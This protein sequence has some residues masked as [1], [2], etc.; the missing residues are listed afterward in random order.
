MLE[1]V[2]HL[3]QNRTTI[4]TEFLAGL[5]TFLAMSYILA[6]N[7]IILGKTGMDTGAIFTA[8]CVAAI[9]GTLIMAFVANWPVGMA[10]G[11]G[12]NA[13]FTYGIVL[14]MGYS[15]Q[16][17]LG[18]VFLSGMIFIVLTATGIRKWLI[19]GV[20]R[21]LRSA[22]A[23]GI[24][25]FLAFVALQNAGII[26]KNDATLISLGDMTQTAPAL[27]S[28]GFAIIVMLSVFK[29]RGA[30]LVGILVTTILSYI[31]APLQHM[32]WQNGTA[33]TPSLIESLTGIFPE[34]VI[35]MPPSL[36][37]TFL[38]LDISGI[39]NTG[40]L[41]ILLVLV[42][43][44]IFDATGTLIGVGQRTGLI[45]DRKSAGLGRALFADSGAILAGSLVGTSSTTAYMESVAGAEVGGR[46]GLT[47]LTIA[48]FFFVALFFSPLF[49]AIPVY[50]VAPAL[51]FVACLMMREFLEIKW[52]DITEFVPATL[53]ALIMPF[54]YSI[55]N[56]LAFGFIAYAV[57][58]TL[59][60]RW[61]DVHLATWVIA[62][63]FV[64]RFI[65]E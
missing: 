15:W 61:R 53:T 38:Q 16:Q 2:F 64:I 49:K 20:P 36:A 28:V 3:K 54:T 34:G 4:G 60:G 44:E 18:A 57:L 65:I 63:L 39:L 40:I 10:P 14:G 12:L 33:D 41:H 42:L 13:F 1:K 37:P 62:I 50:A 24:G 22:V 17:A 32:I 7:P 59:S 19:A 55:A 48:L 25:M 11:M 43:V 56:G 9:I 46:T 27:A 8:T 26:V 45:S 58:K 30:V 35:A 52:D 47:A 21:S 51:I 6:V 31:L 5:T 23:A 29:F